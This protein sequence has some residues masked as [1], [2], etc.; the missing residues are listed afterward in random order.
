MNEHQ[1]IP[2]FALEPPFNDELYG[3]LIKYDK[4]HPFKNGVT[5]VY[6]NLVGIIGQHTNDN[7]L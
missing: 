2:G 1:R 7:E 5:A 3:F 4:A 6:W